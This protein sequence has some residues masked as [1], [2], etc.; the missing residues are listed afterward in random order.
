[1]TTPTIHLMD[2]CKTCNHRFLGVD[3]HTYCS[4]HCKDVGEA[5]YGVTRLYCL[6]CGKEYIVKDKR[7]RFCCATHADRERR[8]LKRPY[9]RCTICNKPYKPHNYRQR[10]CSTECR[11]TFHSPRKTPERMYCVECAKPFRPYR[12][13]QICCSISCSNQHKKN[14]DRNRYLRR[15]QSLPKT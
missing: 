4:K 7:N 13:Y 11:N 9:R 6:F 1:M 5:T 14:S 8:N 3:D 2:Y 12:P 10:F 15:K